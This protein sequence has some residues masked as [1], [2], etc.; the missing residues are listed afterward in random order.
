MNTT[1]GVERKGPVNGMV[2][3]R[4]HSSISKSITAS[5]SN[6]LKFQPQVA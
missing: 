6:L 5:P 4:Q 1:M 3:G 2:I